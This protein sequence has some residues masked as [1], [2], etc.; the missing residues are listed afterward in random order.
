[1]LFEI[2]VGAVLKAPSLSSQLDGDDSKVLTS[3]MAARVRRRSAAIAL[4]LA[5]E[6]AR[7]VLL[8]RGSRRGGG[9][10]TWVLLGLRLVDGDLEVP[11]LRWARPLE[12]PRDGGAPDVVDVAA[13]PIEPVGRSKRSLAAPNR[14]EASGHLGRPSHDR[15]HES[16]GNAVSARSAILRGAAFYRSVRQGREVALKVVPVEKNLGLRPREVSGGGRRLPRALEETV[17][18]PALVPWFDYAMLDGIRDNP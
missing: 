16:H 3:R 17:V 6:R 9:D 15:P 5:A 11:P 12:V 8:P 18:G 1:M 4:V 2:G 14:A 7:R 10:V 13:E